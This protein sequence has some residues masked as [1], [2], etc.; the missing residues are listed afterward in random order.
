MRKLFLAY[1]GCVATLSATSD[2]DTDSRRVTYE[3]QNQQPC[4]V[5]VVEKTGW[6]NLADFCKC[7]A[8]IGVCALWCRIEILSGDVRDNHRVI[9]ELSSRVMRLE[10]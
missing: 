9:S 7:L 6:Q 10:R 5:N 3:L 2:F 1:L 4:L 8:I